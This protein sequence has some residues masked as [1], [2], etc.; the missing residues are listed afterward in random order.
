[1]T[2]KRANSQDQK[3]QRRGRGFRAVSGMLETQVSKA[4]QKRGFAVMR[5]LTHW[6]TI[7]GKDIA[8]IALPVTIGYSR[9]GFGATLTVLTNGANAPILQT[10]LPELR[11]RVNACYGYAAVSRVKITQTAPTGF[12]EGRMSFQ[13]K[14]D[15][16]ASVTPDVKKAS[17]SLARDV[18][19]DALREA[20]ERLGANVMTKSRT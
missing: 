4:G 5:L 16:Q 15:Q 13:H 2:Y 12:H 18:G 3:F 17:Q 14:P 6:E 10:Q 11:T 8:K 20:L 9:D 1:M 7:V 19:S